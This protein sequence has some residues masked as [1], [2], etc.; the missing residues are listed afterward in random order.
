[1]I[2]LCSPTVVALSSVRSLLILA[3]LL[4]LS[5]GIG[6]LGLLSLIHSGVSVLD[7][8]T[9]IWGWVGWQIWGSLPLVIPIIHTH[10][11][12]VVKIPII[13]GIT[14]DM[15]GVRI[16]ATAIGVKTVTSLTTS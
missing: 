5:T 3:I 12:S 15:I 8:M 4:V 13:M 6:L 10:S 11:I 16:L 7:S 1:M 14:G 2:T 9:V